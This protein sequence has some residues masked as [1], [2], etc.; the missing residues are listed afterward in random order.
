MMKIAV[1]GAGGM[2]G[3]DVL[4][5][6]E[7]QDVTALHHG[8]L[9]IT[10]LDQARR[11]LEGQ[12]VVINT[13]AFTA[14][15]AAETEQE[16]AYEVN[17]LGPRTLAIAARETGARLIHLSTDYVF[18]GDAVRP[19][20]ETAPR[21]PRSAYGR[22]K[23]AGEDFIAQEY[24]AGSSIVRTAWLYGEHGPSFPATMLRLARTHPT[25][26]VVTDQRGQPTWS[27]DLALAL[28]EL[29]LSPV[30]SGTFHVTNSGSATWFEFAREIF[31]R[32]GLD[33]ARVL[34]TESSAF[35]R[36]APRPAFS[37]LDNSAWLRAG[38]TP[39][40]PWS[41][42]LTEAQR[43]YGLYPSETVTP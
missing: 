36:P 43:G 21:D 39:L 6:L 9:D 11:V 4:A 20:A 15:D 32:S 35:P 16:R 19:Y 38:L 23:A 17:A 37:L 13:A 1:T 40:R 12:D 25:V 31:A 27:R 41:A 33:P 34:P 28:R 3:H 30:R 2:L 10:D 7:D 24:P 8:D 14:V 26:S 22:T 42:A 5:V 29:A 18:H